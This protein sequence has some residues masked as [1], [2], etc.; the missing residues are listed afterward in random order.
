MAKIRVPKPQPGSMN[1]DRKI[2]DLLKF[3][4]RHIQE[5]ER[6]FAH[7]HRSGINIEA[8]KTEGEAAEYI[9]RVTGRLHARYKVKV[10]K[11]RPGSM[12]KH[13]PISRLLKDGEGLTA[14]P[15]NG[16]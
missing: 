9:R 16:H 10:P 2:S 4:M 3:Q 13:R 1:K 7:H 11:P 12:N 15:P 8:I 6:Q 5:A 14:P